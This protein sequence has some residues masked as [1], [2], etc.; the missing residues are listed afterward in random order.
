[1]SSRAA[2]AMYPSLARAEE[3]TRQAELRGKSDKSAQP[4]WG[5]SNDPM[6]AEPRQGPNGLDRVPG[7]RKLRK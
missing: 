3:Q 1:M 2:A 5:K 7:L 6:W 4:A